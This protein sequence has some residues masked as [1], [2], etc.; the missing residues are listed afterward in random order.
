MARHRRYSIFHI[1]HSPWRRLGGFTLVEAVI[2]VGLL[3]LLTT[4]TTIFVLTVFRSDIVARAE[5]TAVANAQ[6][7]LQMVLIEVRHAERV[8]I[9]TSSFG[10]DSGQLS[11][12][13]PRSNPLNHLVSFTDIYLDNGVVYRR[14]DDGESVLPLTSG[15][16][17]VQV[18]R[19]ERYV[20]GDAEGIR[21]TITVVPQGFSESL[22][23]ARTLTA[24]V[25]AR[26]LTAQ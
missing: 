2:Y 25:S 8:Y 1:P 17:D 22:D 18:L 15:D 11:L 12:R 9:Q 14:R 6:F 21:I 3:L 4:T 16:V 20:N 23:A 26:V 10:I 13:T 5:Q 7:A 24:F 19:F